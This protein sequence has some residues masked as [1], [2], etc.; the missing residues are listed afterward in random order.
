MKYDEF[1]FFNQQLASMLQE[2][3]PLEGAIQQLCVSMRDHALQAEL[4]HLQNDLAKGMPLKEALALRKLPE[5]Y[6]QMVQVGV[7]GNNLAGMLTLLADYYQKV[8]A[9]WIRL[10]G[11]MVYPLIVLAASFVFC[12]VYTFSLGSFAEQ[13]LTDLVESY[14]PYARM[15]ATRLWLPPVLI[16]FAFLG[17]GTGLVTPALQRILRWRLPAFK[18]AAL[19]QLASALGLMLKGGATLSDSLKILIELEK[20]TPAGTELAG[21]HQSLANGHAKFADIAHPSTTFPPLFIW[22]ASTSKGDLADGLDRAAAVYQARAIYRAEIL[23]YAALPVCIMFLGIM[24]LSQISAPFTALI[25]II[26]TLGQS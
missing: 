14:R 3:I 8:G 12:M 13:T 18:E 19:S 9:V 2:G 25:R 24:I 5:F 11:L 17:L 23:L 15:Y 6:I 1:A 4:Q 7:K 21:W 16:G 22:L 20:Q 10:Q 26:T